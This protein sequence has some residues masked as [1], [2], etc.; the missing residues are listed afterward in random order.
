MKWLVQKTKDHRIKGNRIH[1]KQN[2]SSLLFFFFL[3]YCSCRVSSALQFS[4]VKM[5]FTKIFYS[6]LRT[7]VHI[8]FKGGKTSFSFIC[9]FRIGRTGLFVC[10]F[11]L[12]LFF[13]RVKSIVRRSV[14]IYLSIYLTIIPRVSVGYEMVD[15][16]RGAY[17]AGGTPLYKLYRYVPPDRVRYL[18]RFGL[19]TGIVLPILVWNRDWFS[20]ELRECMNVFIVSILKE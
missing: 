3:F 6:I 20:R 16:Q 7:L 4:S 19:K 8:K 13:S 18:R 11:L 10:L 9:K 1:Q 2:S 15:S 17:P 14:S 5:K 12:L